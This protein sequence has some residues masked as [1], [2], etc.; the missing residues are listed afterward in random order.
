MRPRLIHTHKARIIGRIFGRRLDIWTGESFHA[1][2]RS[3]LSSALPSWAC[4]FCLQSHRKVA[5]APSIISTFLAAG[6]GGRWKGK[7]Q[8]SHLRQLP[9]GILLEHPTEHYLNLTGQQ[10]VSWPY[11]TLLE[12]GKCSVLAKYTTT[13]NETGVVIQ[14]G[15]T[16]IR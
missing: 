6:R 3:P 9:T 5:E 16:G 13:S 7:N 2:W 11:L 14:N 8:V 1:E 12:E 10:L 15:G 4:G